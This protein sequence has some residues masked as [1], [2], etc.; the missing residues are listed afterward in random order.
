MLRYSPPSIRTRS[1]R[2]QSP[3]C[4]QLH[5]GRAI[6]RGG[7]EPPLIG[8]EPTVL[9]LDDLAVE[10]FKEQ[11][12]PDF[13]SNAPWGIKNAKGK[14][15]APFGDAEQLRSASS[16]FSLRAQMCF[17]HAEPVSAGQRSPRLATGYAARQKLREK[18]HTSSTSCHYS[19]EIVTKSQWGNFRFR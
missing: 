19:K 10:R 11:G 18:K 4:C 15:F 5:Q 8:S 3:T 17:D 6:A 9:P 12:A 13:L 1:L 16:R 7:V 2:I 14:S